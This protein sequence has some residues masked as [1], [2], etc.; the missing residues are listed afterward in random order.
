VTEDHLPV[1]GT[2]VP[3]RRDS[4]GNGRSRW[5]ST[6]PSSLSSRPTV[7]LHLRQRVHGQDPKPLRWPV[8]SDLLPSTSTSSCSGQFIV[9]PILPLPGRSG[10]CDVRNNSLS[11]HKCLLRRTQVFGVG[12]GSL[13]EGAVDQRNAATPVAVHLLNYPND[14]R[15]AQAAPSP[16]AA[17]QRQTRC[18]S[19]GRTD[20]GSL[21]RPGGSGAR[22][23]STT[24]SSLW[25][26]LTWAR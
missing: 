17:R 24:R 23:A 3:E 12:R 9:V 14:D 11:G 21:W 7:Q 5:R 1:C 16:T 25:G 26:W 20:P 10:P 22:P 8:T 6:L 2:A 18:D 13:P 4:A 15:A 19:R